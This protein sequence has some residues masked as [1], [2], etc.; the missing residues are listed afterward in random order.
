MMSW[1]RRL[2]PKRQKDDP[3]IVEIASEISHETEQL[4]TATA[5]LSRDV[6]AMRREHAEMSRVL[7]EAI[8]VLKRPGSK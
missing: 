4:A 6:N 8:Q 3:T 5:I 2:L 1:L 7:D